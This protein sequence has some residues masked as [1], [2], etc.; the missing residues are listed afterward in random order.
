MHSVRAGTK[1]SWRFAV[2]V[3]LGVIRFARTSEQSPLRSY[4]DC[5]LEALQTDSK[6]D[7]F[8]Q[9]QILTGTH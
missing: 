6:P 2:G 7:V 4:E 5:K 8:H 1:S 3:F 9:R